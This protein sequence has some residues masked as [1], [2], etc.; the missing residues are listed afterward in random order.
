MD[1][2]PREE[3]ERSCKLVVMP[4]VLESDCK[5]VG[6]YMDVWG[7]MFFPKRSPTEQASE[8]ELM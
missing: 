5:F 3:G 4:E 8:C 2:G 7:Y 6:K 1:M